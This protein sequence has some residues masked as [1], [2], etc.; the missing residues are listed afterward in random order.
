MKTCKKEIKRETKK[1]TDDKF[2]KEQIIK[3][4]TFMHSRDLLQAI[5]DE[6]GSY[7]K[8]EIIDIIEK[9]KKGKVN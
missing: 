7:T 6:D 9:F 2:T 4:K 1:V 5:L 8:S 3:S